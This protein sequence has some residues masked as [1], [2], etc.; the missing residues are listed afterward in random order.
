MMGLD[1]GITK[2]AFCP[3]LDSLVKDLPAAT[4]VKHGWKLLLNE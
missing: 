2:I 3:S 1:S 4:L